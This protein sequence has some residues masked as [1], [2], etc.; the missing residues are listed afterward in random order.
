[1]I[2]FLLPCPVRVFASQT[3][4]EA[5]EWLRSLPHGDL[6]AIVIHAREFPGWEN[7][8]SFLRHVRFVRDRHRKVRR[9]ALAAD[10]EFLHLA[11]R[12]AD[13]FVQAEVRSFGYDELQE[14]IAWAGT[15]GAPSNG[16]SAESKA[17]SL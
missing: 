10:G 7:L 16:A 8:G 1:V 9:V 6:Q 5:I 2:G 11:P 4:G 13:H 3:L 17:A 14:A 12:I 15:Q